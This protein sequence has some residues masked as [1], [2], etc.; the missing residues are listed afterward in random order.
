MIWPDIYCL[1]W[2][3]AGAYRTPALVNI[4]K[5]STFNNNKLTVIPAK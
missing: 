4:N 3:T 5:I 1:E 2:F